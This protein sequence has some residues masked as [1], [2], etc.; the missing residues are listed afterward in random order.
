MSQIIE[1]V[2]YK[3]LPTNSIRVTSIG[4]SRIGNPGNPASDLETG[5]IAT[6]LVNAVEIDWNGAQWERLTSG[7]TPSTINTT[8]DLIKT[9]NNSLYS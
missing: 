6:K 1:G 3:N 2:P 7:S 4:N 8:A 5:D 9:I